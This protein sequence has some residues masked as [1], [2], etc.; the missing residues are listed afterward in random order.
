M[1]SIARRDII[2]DSIV[3]VYLETGE[4]VSSA[5]IA[6]SCGIGISSATVPK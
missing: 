6:G 5:H 1:K 2:I 3:S 4:P